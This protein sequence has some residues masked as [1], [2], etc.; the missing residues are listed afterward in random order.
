MKPA[1]VFPVL[2]LLL[3]F[4]VIACG[5]PKS[6]APPSATPPPA[7]ST[8][9]PPVYEEIAIPD[10][11]SISGVVTFTG[12]KPRLAPRPVPTKNPEICGHGPKPSEEVILGA[13]GTLQNVV[14]F[15]DGIRKGKKI[16]RDVP[17]VLD[18][19]KCD[20]V[21]HV[22]A[23]A[24]NST[25]D[26]LNSDDLLHNVHGKWNGRETVFNLAM[27]LKGQKIPRKLTKP[28]II[29]LQCDAA[30]T[31][32]KGYIVVVENPYFATSDKKGAFS[33]TD[34][35]PGT[36]RVKAWHEKFGT[37]EQN[38]TVSPGADSKISLAYK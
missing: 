12:P 21:P 1:F 33:V 5:S 31:W 18:Q 8:E 10:P 7:A 27:P 22:Q 36:H 3:A 32:M 23:A 20:Y 26:I 25:I 15:I 35:P 34:V 30:H 24:V 11:G 28:G 17:L 2:L 37:L 19:K 6:E 9:P 38:I 4:F 16:A 13:G 29:N 14:V